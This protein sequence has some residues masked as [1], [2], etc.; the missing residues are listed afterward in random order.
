MYIVA[1]GWNVELKL[2][3]FKV[4]QINTEQKRKDLLV[5]IRF[6]EVSNS[7]V[8]VNSYMFATGPSRRKSQDEVTTK[9]K[10]STAWYY[11]ALKTS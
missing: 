10:L 7:I 6:E 4:D 1:S 8:E 11:A 5:F 2:G 9:S 3:V